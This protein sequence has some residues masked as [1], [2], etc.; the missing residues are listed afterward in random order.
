MRA[1]VQLGER[2]VEADAFQM[3]HIVPANLRRFVRPSAVRATP[4]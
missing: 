3:Q 4:Q 1:D 2:A